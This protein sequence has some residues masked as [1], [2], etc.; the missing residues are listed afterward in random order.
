MSCL[1]EKI[2]PLM[3]EA[4]R[5]FELGLPSE[6][7]ELCPIQKGVL[8]KFKVHYYS[9]VNNPE[10]ISRDLIQALAQ[11]ELSPINGSVKRLVELKSMCDQ[12]L[13]R[14]LQELNELN[15]STVNSSISNPS[16]EEKEKMSE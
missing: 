10:K 11:C 9:R 7:S 2:L 3:I 16:K 12:L 13:E 8:S 6:G 1:V 4:H 5:F 15:L 14:V